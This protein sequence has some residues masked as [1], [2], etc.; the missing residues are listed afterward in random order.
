MTAVSPNAVQTPSSGWGRPD[1]S[2][3]KTL[4][5]DPIGSFRRDEKGPIGPRRNQ[6]GAR[7]GVPGRPGGVH[8]AGLGIGSRPNER[9]VLAAHGRLVRR[10]A[11]AMLPAGLE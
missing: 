10:R 3:S 5:R 11:Q 6:M 1:P 7:G 9:L 8:H 4:S 2:G